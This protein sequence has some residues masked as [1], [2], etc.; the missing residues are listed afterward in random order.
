MKNVNLILVTVLLVSC[1]G[2]QGQQTPNLNQI[3]TA[4]T[5]V[6]ETQA[7]IQKAPTATAV[8][9][10]IPTSTVYDFPSWMSHPDTVMLAALIRDD[11]E[12]T[13]KI[14]FF[15]AATGEKFE[16]SPS[17]DF[18]GF[19]WHDNMN[20]GLL[21]EDMMTSYTFNLQS[22]QVFVFIF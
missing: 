16:M 15:N 20:F 14:N 2:I 8:S 9:T 3:S 4:S 21:A 18:G 10:T 7:P 6:A 22:G 17:I 12:G 11:T 5:V 13:R 19:F 1:S